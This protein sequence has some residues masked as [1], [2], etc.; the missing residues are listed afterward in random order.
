MKKKSPIKLVR[1]KMGISQASF[2]KMLNLSRSAVAFYESDERFPKKSTAY[3]LIDI[4]KSRGI[5][6]TL[7][8]IYPR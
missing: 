3:K 7:E 5:H 4:A 1:L 6:V 8:D 2:A